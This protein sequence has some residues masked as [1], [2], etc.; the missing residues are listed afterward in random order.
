MKPLRTQP[1]L[2]AKAFGYTGFTGGDWA[3]AADAATKSL[4]GVSGVILRAAVDPMSTTS[5]AALDATKR[6]SD[7]FEPL[8]RPQTV[9]GRLN[10][11]PVPF[12]VQ[13][14]RVLGSA[15]VQWTG[16]NAASPATDM[17]FDLAD[18]LDIKK[19]SCIVV[20]SDAI[21]RLGGPLGEAMIDAELSAAVAQAID[22]AFLDPANA[23]SAAKPAS[24]A[25]GAIT[26]TSSGDPDTDFISM[27]EHFRGDLRKASWVISSRLGA[28]LNL[29]R[30]SGGASNY[31]DVG[32]QGGQIAGLPAYT[33]D[34]VADDTSGTTIMLIDESAILLAEDGVRL[35]L[36]RE[37]SLHMNTAPSGSAQHVSLWQ[38]NS[39][40]IK[41]VQTINWERT[42]DNA[43]VSMHVGY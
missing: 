16:E 30:D 7:S 31:P 28:R 17:A 19:V 12:K 6:A 42:R 1:S 41:I 36:A 37:G 14:P 25:N 35:E 13:V 27:L 43:V 11:R 32:A 38:S 18:A 3:M 8:V 23:G 34:N 2:F 20:M 10:L 24:V 40:A 4:D 29:R 21:L 22:E 39:V 33:T 26:L 5:L 15:T 9:V